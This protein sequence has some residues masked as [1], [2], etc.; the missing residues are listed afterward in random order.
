MLKRA[1]YAAAASAPVE[2]AVAVLERADRT[3]P[4]LLRVL[5]YHRVAN[6]AQ[7]P[8]LYPRLTVS[9]E[10]FRRQMEFV[11]RHYR[12]I[13]MPELLDAARP[14]GRLPEKAVLITFDDATRDFLEYAAP[15]LRRY[16]LPATVFVPT[17]FPGHPERLFWWDR[18][19]G[20]VEHAAGLELIDTPV[21][22]LPV[23]TA[24]AR[25]AAFSRL[26]AYVKAQPHDEAMGWVENF[27]QDL[28]A[29]AYRN[30]V[31]T[32]PELRS[33]VHQGFCL[34]AHTRT[35][36]MMPRLSKEAMRAE[37]V[38]AL[39][40][41]RRETGS[42][43]PIFAYPSGGTNQDVIDT[44]RGEGICLAF[45]TER[46]LDDFYQADRLQLRRL[47]VGPK[48]PLPLLRAQLLSW[49]RPLYHRLPNTTY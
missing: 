11:A 23:G 25:R 49:M 14:E 35:H 24:P 1:L 36:P 15:V 9:P 27:C 48:T 43:L 17:A 2:A 8:Q 33:L 12:P 39:D 44:L 37:T 21:G 13:A 7:T 6:A 38:G 46:G 3:P 20:A 42:E 34:G 47:N 31:M 5:T 22:R 45:T 41:L 4:G 10:A 16:R 18:L 28:E 30:P 40:D 26:R 32:W 29:P 19:Y